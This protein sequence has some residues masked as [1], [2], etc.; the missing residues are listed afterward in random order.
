MKAKVNKVN[1]QIVQDDPYRLPANGVVHVTDPNL[2]LSPAL[3]AKAGPDVVEACKEIG[4]CMV[5]SA[6]ITAAGNLPFEKMIHAVAPRWGE[7][8]ERGRLANLTLK[9][10]RL[11][12]DHQLKSLSFPAIATGTLGYPLESSAHIMLKEIFDFTYEDLRYLRAIYIG[13]ESAIALDAFNQELARLSR[14]WQTSGTGHI[15]A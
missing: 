15:K 9:C 10:L 6:V 13:V 5:G 3:G 14:E 1:I 11:A 12:E 2:S 7:G 8:S 4:W